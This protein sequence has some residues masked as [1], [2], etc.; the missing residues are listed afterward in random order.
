MGI[1]VLTNKPYKY[2]QNNSTAIRRHIND[3]NHRCDSDSFKMVG[4][5]A[6]DFHLCIKESLLILKEKPQLNV[7]DESLPLYVFH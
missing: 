2:N 3:D 1:S 6:N 5:A 7:A 4:S